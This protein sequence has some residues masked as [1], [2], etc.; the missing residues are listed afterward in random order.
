MNDLLTNI[1]YKCT[2][3][4]TQEPR[5]TDQHIFNES[6]TRRKNLAMAWINNKKAYDML[7]QS[8]IL[9]C[10]KLSKIPNQ[11][12]KFIEKTM[13][14]WRM[15]LTA[16]WF[17]AW[18]NNLAEVKIQRGIF[19]GDALSPLLVGIAMIPL[20][21]ILSRCTAGYKLGKSQKKKKKKLT[22]TSNWLPKT[23]KNWKP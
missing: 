7:P 2:Q 12:V 17:S 19:Y 21:Y 13:Q 4:G 14:T 6:K 18:G 20:N 8:W 3:K 15:E 23:K 5:Y 1:P 16:G 11:V 10:L 9:H 22:T